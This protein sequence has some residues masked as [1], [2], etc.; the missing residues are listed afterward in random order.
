MGGKQH[1]LELR[2]WRGKNS[3]IQ[4]GLLAELFLSPKKYQALQDDREK[5][6]N[7]RKA[8]R[9]LAEAKA[10]PSHHPA[11]TPVRSTSPASR[12]NVDEGLALKLASPVLTPAVPAQI[13]NDT[14]STKSRHSNK[15]NSNVSREE[16]SHRGSA[17][18]QGAIERRIPGQR[19]DDEGSPKSSIQ[20]TPKPSNFSQREISAP[21]EVP[22][23]PQMTR[24]DDHDIPASVL[25]SSIRGGGSSSRGRALLPTTKTVSA[26]PEH[27]IR[28]STARS[29]NEQAMPTPPRTSPPHIQNRR[30][31]S[32]RPESSVSQRNAPSSTSNHSN[33]G[34]TTPMGRNW[35]ASREDSSQG[36]GYNYASINSP[37]NSTARPD[38][39]SLTAG[40]SQQRGQQ[41]NQYQ[42]G[43]GQQ[44]PQT[45]QHQR[46]SQ[47]PRV[48]QDHSPFNTYRPH[49]PL[50]LQ[51]QPN[52]TPPVLTQQL[53]SHHVSNS[54][55][56]PPSHFYTPNL[57][58]LFH[59]DAGL[60]WTNAQIQLFT[61]QQN[62]LH[63]FGCFPG[64]HAQM[65]TMF[66]ATGPL[67]GGT[68]TPAHSYGSGGCP[69]CDGDDFCF[70]CR[71][72]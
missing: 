26:R 33:R 61:A 56:P 34:L 31:H 21:A 51:D 7:A 50:R 9:A 72:R 67:G 32:V 44:S 20:N 4:G 55:S 18:P 45:S 24:T 62:R 69:H 63:N 48:P 1:D 25:P 70:S 30:S 59:T 71:S 52:S 65:P 35:E 46:V 66:C 41:G 28:S 22:R 6:R 38:G 23:T 29:R 10:T 37:S 19:V 5:K 54:P 43:S 40:R 58:P 57:H 16:G 64:I 47:T 14:G 60:S 2:F 36:G 42:A 12:H 15:I 49:Q 27:P 68:Y 11:K 17:L 13:G 53:Q 8:A 39:S 3:V